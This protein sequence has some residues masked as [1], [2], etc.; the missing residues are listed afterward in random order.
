MRA[1]FLLILG[2]A[3]LLQNSGC[4]RDD[5]NVERHK[6]GDVLGNYSLE[7]AGDFRVRTS[8]LRSRVLLIHFFETES[9]ECRAQV[10][11]I[12]NLWFRHRAAGMNVLGVCPETGG[13]E[14]LRTVE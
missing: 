13:T 1:Q 2:L 10:R 5:S 6:A 12:K 9:D 4:A 3:I 11:Q 8:E 7:G 14:V